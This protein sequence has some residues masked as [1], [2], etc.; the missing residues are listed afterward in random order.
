M[1]GVNR[2]FFK[3]LPSIELRM[4]RIAARSICFTALVIACFFA[5]TSISQELADSLLNELNLAKTDSHKV[6]ILNELC[7]EFGASEPS[8]ALEFGKRSIELS[9]K[10]GYVNGAAT[11]NSNIG[12]AYK[13]SGD[14]EK[15]IEHLNVALALEIK[16]NDIRGQ[17]SNHN[18][19]GNTFKYIAEYA[20]SLHH[21][22]EAI[23]LFDKLGEEQSVASVK[24][25]SAY[26]HQ[27]LNEFE[28]AVP[29]CKQVLQMKKQNGS[30][31]G[32]AK[33]CLCLGVSYN[34]MEQLDSALFYFE[35]SLSILKSLN[36]RTY[37]P[38]A[39]NNIG[40][41]YSQLGDHE[42]AVS[43][44]TEAIAISDSLGHMNNVAIGYSD[45]GDVLMEAKR[46]QEAA[47][48]FEQSLQLSDKT[49][50]TLVQVNVLEKK[51]EA[52]SKLG[53]FELA[54]KTRLDYEALRDSIHS[55]E[56]EKEL[57]KLQE[58][59]DAEKREQEIVRL[60]IEQESAQAKANLSNL[61]L[62]SALVLMVVLGASVFLY[63]K[64]RKSEEQQKLAV[65]EQ[66]ALRSQMNPHFIFNS[67]NSIQRL[68][69]EG[70]L[71]KANDHVADFG[72]LLRM[73]LD[74]SGRSQISLADE[75]ETLKL[76][77]DLEQMRTD[78]Q[79]SYSIDVDP[80]I[81][82]NSSK[83]PPLIIQPFVENA[84]WHGILPKNEKGNVN[85][86]I[87]KTESGL[88]CVITDDGI[89]IEESLKNKSQTHESKAM[90]ITSER[91]NNAVV[92]EQ[93]PEGGT[94]ITIK[95]PLG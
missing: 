90:K 40:S 23:R 47:A 46:Y 63:L 73:I 19:L 2:I 91:L 24:M 38:A 65:L 80:S 67:L 84:I 4:H 15:A 7:W 8:K 39:L 82:L 37:L 25:N 75:L 6:V 93:L 79:I 72:K 92:A 69:V 88:L 27:Y 83:V 17:A 77:I 44:I 74:N 64:Q 57:L 10:I 11:A 28:K 81:D 16:T 76:Y 36:N 49:G 56:K 60:R 22:Q 87:S 50:S 45:L 51:S 52:L 68:Y 35:Q 12:R 20:K 32:E 86:R 54:Y 62:A 94:R 66:K 21:F 78:N 59:F 53:K 41:V 9:D 89:G 1:I 14:F 3:T 26:L 61:L 71:D 43:V 95:I 42:K 18:E 31:L 5:E 55:V 85:I 48:A 29:L 70:N 33:S 58:E 34:G 30:L 13:L